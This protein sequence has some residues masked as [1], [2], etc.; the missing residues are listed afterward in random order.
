MDKIIIFDMDGVLFDTEQ[1]VRECWKT[2]AH[3]QSIVGIEEVFYRCIGTNNKSTKQ[4][5]MKHYGDDFQYDEFRKEASVMFHTITDHDGV[6][7][8]SGVIELLEFLK[9]N[10]YRIGLASS[11]R[12][13]MVKDE[14]KQMNL[15]DYFDIVIGGDM[16]T[17][18]K[19]DPEIFLKCQS[20]LGGSISDTYVIEDSYNGIRAAH[21]AGMK[22]IMVPDL[23]APD[24]EMENLSYCIKKSLLEVKEFLKMDDWK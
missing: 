11:T 1:L 19:P 13:E 23:I 16:V 12:V 2:V 14:L 18:S 10:H 17:N 22:P 5:M 6:P 15:L 3:N 7:M 4:I 24:E 9:S 8:K 20:L 21:R